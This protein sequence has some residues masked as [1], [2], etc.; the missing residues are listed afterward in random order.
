MRR[1]LVPVLFLS[2]GSLL[3]SADPPGPAATRAEVYKLFVA[4]LVPLTPGKGKFPATFTMGS[5]AKDAP[6]TEKPAI[7]IT[8]KAPFAIGRHEVTQELYQHVMGKNPS[9]WTGRRNSVEMV[10]WDEAVEFCRK[11]TTALR[12]AKLI[13]AD[14]VIR[15][16]SEAEWEY[17]C[18]A[19]TQTSW[20]CG[21]RKADLD[22]HAWTDRNSKGYDPQVGAKKA[23][24]WGLYDMHGY[25]WEWCADSWSPS[26]ADA[27]SDGQPRVTKT[28]K[29]RLLRGGSWGDPAEASRSAFRKGEPRDQRSDRIGFRC[30]KAKRMADDTPSD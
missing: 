30:V 18:R 8:F 6:E 24:P 13:A 16:P 1:L 5:T 20:S 22:A 12:E 7:E 9:R 10:N 26:H 21:D 4:E 25:V 27:K 2:L 28:E 11:L 3:H 17:A 23:N 19:G 14:E 29:Q 15:L